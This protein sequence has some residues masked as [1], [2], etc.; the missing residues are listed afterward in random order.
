M[1]ATVSPFASHIP[2]YMLYARFLVLD[3]HTK[4]TKLSLA[5]QSR[6]RNRAWRPTSLTLTILIQAVI[7]MNGVGKVGPLIP[8]LYTISLFP[9]FLLS[10]HLKGKDGFIS[11]FLGTGE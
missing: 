11:F 4:N 7:P 10:Y 3:L 1:C 8:P 9:S 2:F 6:D 5:I